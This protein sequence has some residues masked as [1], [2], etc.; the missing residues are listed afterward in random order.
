VVGLGYCAYDILAIVPGLPEF[1]A[2]SG[3]HLT[4][5]VFDGGGQVGTAL[6]TLAHLG[7][8]TG[9]IGVLGDDPAGSFLQ[10]LFTRDGVDL[11]RLRLR[12]DV[13]TNICLLL[14]E[15]GTARRAIL[16]HRR[17][18][19]T[20]LTLREDDRLYI[21]S[22]KV[23][24][25]DGQFMPAA[26][27]AAHWARAAGVK[28]CFDGNHPRPGLHELLPMVDWLVVAEPFPQAYTGEH[29]LD[30]SAYELLALG[31]KILVVTQSERGCEVWTPHERFQVPGF[32]ADAVDTTGAGDAYHGAFVYAMLH[33]WDLHRTATFANALA[34]INC[35]TLGGRRG[36]PTLA[37]VEAFISARAM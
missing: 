36:L 13:G 26:I 35:Q 15:Q 11:A 29:D 16:C 28:V 1:D 34:A 30:R 20:D 9:Y 12:A 24:H 14:V 18:Q 7:V 10:D 19:P 2:V 4:D 17:V 37:Q 27:Q 5:L 21:Q 25:L 3:I 6:A 31:A 8:R 32:Q 23:L 22:A 33:G